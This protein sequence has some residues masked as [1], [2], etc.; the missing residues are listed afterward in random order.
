MKQAYFDL[1]LS[2]PNDLEKSE[3]IAEMRRTIVLSSA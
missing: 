2:N 1:L 3:T